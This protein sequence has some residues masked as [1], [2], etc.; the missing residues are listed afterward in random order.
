MATRSGI[1]GF[2]RN[3]A[4]ILYLVCVISLL[5]YIYIDIQNVNKDMLEYHEPDLEFTYEDVTPVAGLSCLECH[6]DIEGADIT[7]HSDEW[8]PS[9]MDYEMYCSDCHP[10]KMA[11]T[12]NDDWNVSHIPVDITC[13]DCHAGINYTMAGNDWFSSTHK[14]AG[15]TCADCHGGDPNNDVDAMSGN[16]IGLPEREDILKICGGCHANESAEFKTSIHNGYILNEDG[17]T[18]VANTCTDCHGIHHIEKHNNPESPVYTLNSPDTCGNCH[19]SKFYSFQDSYHGA[20]VVFGGE[21]VASCPDCHGVHGIKP[22][23]DPDSIVHSSNIADTCSGGSS[24]KECHGN[25]LDLE[26]VAQ[27]H[28]HYE[29]SMGERE[30]VYY[31][32]GLNLIEL[33]PM[34]YKLAILGMMGGLIGLMFLENYGWGKIVGRTVNKWKAKKEESETEEGGE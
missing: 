31:I 5:L 29:G 21:I 9:H 2:I 17:E 10:D 13:A 24:S 25:E 23:S 20:Y 14:E 34:I 15:T 32:F 33:I 7:I 27:G 8:W 4:W 30:E 12:F 28:V 11:A 26:L 16:F 3:Y 19:S 18:I 22:V 1:K 6:S